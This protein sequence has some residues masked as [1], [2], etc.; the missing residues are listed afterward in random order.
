MLEKLMSTSMIDMNGWEFPLQDLRDQC[1]R[2][3]AV[4][5]WPVYT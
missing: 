3:H 4:S 2:D 1:M 5:T